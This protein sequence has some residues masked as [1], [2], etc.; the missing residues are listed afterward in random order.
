M[1]DNDIA[2]WISIHV[3]PY[4]HIARNWLRRIDAEGVDPDDIVQEAYA[5]LARLKGVSHIQS[6]RAY[7][8]MTVRNLAFEH[9]RRQ[10]LVRIDAMA[11]ID[12]LAIID[13]RPSIEAELSGRQLLVL[14]GALIDRLPDRCRAVLKLRKVEGLSQ[15]ETAERLG[16][17]ENVVEKQTAI[18]LRE[19]LRQLAERGLED[20][21][22]SGRSTFRDQKRRSGD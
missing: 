16:I 8:M 7:F 14:V 1:A 11:E 22:S 5:H 10:K 2:S 13:D 9:L 15:K 20:A 6:G 19:V 4:E 18:G 12:G 21:I 17:T 3:L